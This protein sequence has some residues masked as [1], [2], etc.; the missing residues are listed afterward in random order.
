M[1]LVVFR[2]ERSLKDCQTAAGSP[3]GFLRGLN[4]IFGLI[5]PI[6]EKIQTNN[7]KKFEKIQGNTV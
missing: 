2:Q 4:I 5:K 1:R 6:N 7:L 3:I